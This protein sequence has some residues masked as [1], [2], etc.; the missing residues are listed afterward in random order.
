MKNIGRNPY[1]GLIFV[2]KSLKSKL[3][4]IITPENKIVHRKHYLAMAST[5]DDNDVIQS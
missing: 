2:V 4:L 5:L 1:S 3:Y